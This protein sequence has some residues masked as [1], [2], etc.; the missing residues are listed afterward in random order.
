MP[1]QRIASGIEESTDIL[2]GLKEFYNKSC[3]VQ[4]AI[5]E[6]DVDNLNGFLSIHLQDIYVRSYSIN[7]NTTLSHANIL[8][9]YLNYT[10]GDF[11]I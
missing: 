4:E 10:E 1:L 5:T 9:P 2:S 8:K 11:F 3:N 7:I 6:E